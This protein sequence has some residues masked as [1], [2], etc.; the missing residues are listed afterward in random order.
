[1]IFLAFLIFVHLYPGGQIGP[2][3]SHRLDG[4]PQ[5]ALAPLKV[6]QNSLFE[7][8]VKVNRNTVIDIKFRIFPSQ[9]SFSSLVWT[10]NFTRFQTLQVVP[11]LTVSPGN[12]VMPPGLTETHPASTS[13]TSI[14]FDHTVAAVIHLGTKRKPFCQRYGINTHINLS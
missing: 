4:I 1:M 12:R 2:D 5:K 9:S 7:Q 10:S 3:G 11:D 6:S 13:I 8:L 14:N